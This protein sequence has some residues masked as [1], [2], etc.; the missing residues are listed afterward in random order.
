VSRIKVCYVSGYGRSGSTLLGQILGQVDGFCNVGEIRN[1]FNIFGWPGWRC[2]CGEVLLE[3]PFWKEIVSSGSPPLG[4]IKAETINDLWRTS[5]R[6]RHVPR[7]WWDLAV[8]HRQPVPQ[9]AAILGQLYRSLAD[10]SGAR[11]VVDVSKRPADALIAYGIPDVDLYLVHLIRDPRAVSYSWMREKPSPGGHGGRP[12]R[13][14]RP[15][16]TARQWL[17]F[18]A[19]FAAIIHPTVGRG[20]YLQVH[21]EDLVARPRETASTIVSFLGESPESLPFIDEHTMDLR[22]THSASGN[23]TRF[24]TG[25]VEIRLDDEWRSKMTGKDRRE[26]TLWA[27]ALMPFM[28]YPLR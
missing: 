16:V 7:I 9:Y 8:R 10:T 11:V 23:P 28:G 26:A 21:Y 13:R 6:T 17:Y 4:T 18:N 25:A 20:R 14:A 27:G 12:M 2:G 5:F 3:C 15:N 1:L 22:P 24:N 19:A